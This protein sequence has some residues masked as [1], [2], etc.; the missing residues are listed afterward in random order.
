MSDWAG[1]VDPSSR[2]RIEERLA[3]YERE[4]TT[5]IAVAI[6]P[7]LDGEDLADFTNR[8]F[9]RFKL[10]QAGKN[11]GVLL[12][13]FMAE[14]KARIE[15]GYGLEGRLTDLVASS[16]LSDVLAPR[17]RER[18]YAGGIDAACRAIVAATK[19]EFKAAP[20]RRRSSSRT[21]GPLAFVILILLV[22][23]IRAVAGGSYRGSRR[24]R[25][26]SSGPVIWGGGGGGLF[27]GGGGF[28]G[29]GF[30]GG[31]GMSGGGGASGGW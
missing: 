3:A 29:G 8:L 15:V 19:G 5:Q 18:D 12:A 25:F 23:F 16:I 1:I 17:F 6:F 27:G 13:V 4:S 24:G 31:G 22:F 28:S 26:R 7:S 2:A 9:E 20:S 30:S 21:L 11:N 14:R 10:G